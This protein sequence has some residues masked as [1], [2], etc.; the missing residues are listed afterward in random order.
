MGFA[1]LVSGVSPKLQSG[2]G[3]DV[4]S[5]ANRLLE[6]AAGSL[7]GRS[8]GAPFAFLFGCFW[9]QLYIYL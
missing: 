1:S 6:E 4:L 9:D 5:R 3:V 7:R 2:G 8:C